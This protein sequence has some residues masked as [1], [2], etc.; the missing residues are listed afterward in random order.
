MPGGGVHLLGGEAQTLA[1]ASLEW[2]LRELVPL[3]DGTRTVDDLV[4]RV[5]DVAASD[6]R[7]VLHLLQMHGMLEEGDDSSTAEWRERREATH[8][9]QMT[10][11]SRY[12]RLT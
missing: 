5:P 2:V 11:F 7:D 6:L 3:L 1:G 10:F 9:A 12:L 8:G 4:A